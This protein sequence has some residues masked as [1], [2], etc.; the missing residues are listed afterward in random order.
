MKDKRM[1]SVNLSKY[2]RIY[3]DS[4]KLSYLEEGEV[5]SWKGYI[6]A[7]YPN[8]GDEYYTLDEEL[9]SIEEAII[10]D[11]LKQKREKLVCNSN[12]I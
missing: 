3:K 12:K 6:E 5:D 2:I 9:A 4:I 1:I 7:M 10:A 11:Y 8:R